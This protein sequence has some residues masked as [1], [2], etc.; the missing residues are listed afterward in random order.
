M[1]PSDEGIRS[2]LEWNSTLNPA[3]APV[4]T[5]KTK[6]LRKTSIIATIGPKVNTVEKLAELRLAGVNV[7]DPNGRPVAIALDTKGPEIRT[8]LTTNSADYPVPAGHEFIIS[9]DPKYSECC[10][11]KVMFVDY[12]NLPKVTAP[13]KL[14]YVDDGI[15]SLL[16]LSIDGTNVRV[17]TLNSGNISSRKGVNLPKTD[18]DLP[19]LSEKDKKDLQFGV[20][21]GVDMIFA[22]FIRRGQDIR[23]IRTV[24]G[25]DGANIKII[26]KVE[27]EQGVQNFDEILKETD[28]VMVARGD[29][30]IEIPASQVFLAQKMMIAK[31][32]IVG[33][34]VIVATQM[35]EYNPR[36]TRAEVSDVANAVLDGA[37]C[38]MLSG[39]TAKGQYPIQ[40]VLMMAETCL[41]AESAIC[42][43]PLYDELR[44]I[45][46]RPTETPE[47]VAIASVAASTEQ[48]A[49]AIL[50]LS[51]SGNTARLISKYRPRVP[52]LTVTRNEQ[53]ARQIHLH[54]GCYP[55]W[56]TEPRGVQSHQ[57]QTDVDNRIRF[58]LRNAL[59][60]GI[61]TPGSTIIA[62]QGWK[63][64]LG[65]T[66]TL[67]IL[68]VPTDP[69]DL[70]LH[71]ARFGRRA[72]SAVLLFFLLLLVVICF[73]LTKRFGTRAKKWPRPFI[74]DPSTL[75]F[76]REDLQRIWH[77]EISSGHY[78]S[79]RP[80]P[81]EI[82][83]RTIPR[84]P[85]IPPKRTPSRG[86]QGFANATRG[87]GPQRTY[88]EVKNKPGSAGSYPP[89]PVPGS[90]ADLDL[91]MENCDFSEKKY[92]RDCLEFLRI[93]SGLDT[94]NRLIREPLDDWKY[95]YMEDADAAGPISNYDEPPYAN[96]KPGESKGNSGTGIMEKP[97]ISLPPPL[98]HR[99][100]ASL[101]DP[102][103]DDNPRLFHMFWT[104]PFTDKPYTAILSF[105]YTQNT[106]LHLKNPDPSIC[107][108]Q[109]W[110]WINPGPAAAVPNPSA[111]RDMYTELKQ[112]PWAS[113]FLHPRFKGVIHFKLW[114]TTEQL[115]GVPEL[116]YEWRK[117]NLFNS[118]G[119][120]IAVPQENKATDEE[121]GTATKTDSGDMLNRA[122]SK[123]SS[124]YD[125]MSVILS[126]MARFV[127]CHRFGGTYLDADTIFL[128]DWEEL[129]GW[130]GAFAYRW[131]RLPK[132]NT[133]VLHM[134]K[135]SA[136]GTFLFRTALKNDLDF[137]PMTIS[138]YT[139]DAHLE[140][141]L[142]RLP[143]A[144]FDSA[145]L[146]TENYQRDRPPQPYFTDFAHF[147]ETPMV[148]SAAPQAMGFDGFFKGAYS[149][150][151][152]NFWWKPFDPQRNWPDLG[153]KFMAG[154]RQ[155]RNSTA[156]TSTV[157]EGADRR[158]LDW[159]TVLKRT[160]ESYIRGE[161]PNMY[162]EW[163]E[164]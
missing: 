36:P 115:D 35:L 72:G 12:Q 99:P 104:G 18:V 119:N 110:M 6:F 161:R 103:D 24:L 46:T 94:G 88:L 50:V 111:L 81:E 48:N 43:P 63:G 130:K 2:Q 73:A 9:T 3:Y 118:G 148:S 131:S 87:V 120:V 29:L 132:Y 160:F 27:N 11:D 102:C 149:Y 151:F 109:F 17:R 156:A 30:G 69:A 8:G 83:F 33:K 159:A 152:H 67:R 76:E 62:V 133:A 32:N 71:I 123:S 84:N 157:L 56:Y 19:A 101:S 145:W 82:G 143:D 66:N 127:L 20:Q 91:I 25:P 135:N 64:G 61:I 136:L 31:C 55:F 14:I 97:P 80:I 117:R 139:K 5:E 54:R 163:L 129:W 15:L 106:G 53:T 10:D 105:L 65:H 75:I 28:G 74:G 52:I 16:V 126:D 68:T 4:P 121:E 153:E 39:E 140:E 114:N 138:R 116:K 47:T 137:H 164:W 162:G 21:N 93:G 155:A 134:N 23:D 112:N 42:Y 49:S 89:R 154:E 86:V 150:H 108:P 60:L 125:R 59:A 1:Y 142:L 124:T 26:A 85:A 38:V 98:D 158:D 146:N 141:L 22:S 96:I 13:G 40:S 58:G 51:T 122:G 44:A 70:E 107:R 128:R 113:P 92:V 147:F 78:P 34:P 41:L 37:D 79:R 45:Q 90:V 57:W 100:Y 77:W 95:V 144:L 7:A